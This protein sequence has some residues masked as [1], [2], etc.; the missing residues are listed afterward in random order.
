MSEVEK[1]INGIIFEGEDGLRL[2][3]VALPLSVLLVYLL[4][5]IDF[6]SL[7]GL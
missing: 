3:A 4:V 6:L 5:K 1:F 7:I 2:S